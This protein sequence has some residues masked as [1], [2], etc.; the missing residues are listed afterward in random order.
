[1]L[2]IF[3]LSIE[4]DQ[5]LTLQNLNNELATVV[6]KYFHIGIQLGI[7]E[8]Q[9][10]E[11]ESNYPEAR[12]CFSELISY[13]L[14]NSERVSWDSLTTALESPSVNEKKLASELREKYLPSLLSKSQGTILIGNRTHTDKI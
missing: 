9:L 10:K 5:R 13:W 7:P 14:K 1:M 2:R 4:S 8:H 6:S 3:F 11:F 12:R